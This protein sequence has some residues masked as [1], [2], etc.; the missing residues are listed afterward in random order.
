ME[1]RSEDDLLRFPPSWPRDDG[2]EMVVG[3]ECPDA[4]SGNS[5]IGD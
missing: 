5:T 3:E 2:F 4:Q 1:S